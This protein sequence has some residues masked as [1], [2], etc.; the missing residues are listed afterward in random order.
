MAFQAA[1]QFVPAQMVTGPLIAPGVAGILS[2]V[3][4]KLAAVL[5]P[6]LF[7]AVTEIVPDVPLSVAEI[8]LVVDVPVQPAGNDHV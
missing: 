7:V 5:V 1:H 8:L 2:T 3:T 4:T 6:Q